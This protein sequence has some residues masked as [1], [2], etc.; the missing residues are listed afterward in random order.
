[1]EWEIKFVFD[2]QLKA[3]GK[4]IKLPTFRQG[5]FKRHVHIKMENYVAIPDI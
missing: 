2:V 4:T 5:M 3:R 1:M